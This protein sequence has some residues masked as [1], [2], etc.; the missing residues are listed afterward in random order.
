MIYRYTSVY[1]NVIKTTKSMSLLVDSIVPE[2]II[3]LVRTSVLVSN[4]K[5]HNVQHYAAG[6]STEAG[7]VRPSGAP[8]STHYQGVCVV[9]CL[10]SSHRYTSLSLKPPSRC[11][12]WWIVYR[13]ELHRQC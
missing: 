11:H 12:C 3:S 1:F 10:C 7:N 5:F 6:V 8:S 2:G 13:C 4:L 9:H